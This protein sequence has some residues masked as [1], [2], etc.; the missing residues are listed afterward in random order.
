M[1]LTLDG[2]CA[3][4][5]EHPE[6]EKL[7][8]AFDKCEAHFLEYKPGHFIACHWFDFN[9]LDVHEQNEFWAVGTKH[10]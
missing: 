10:V 3:E 4:I 5:A 1:R 8:L 6:R 2:V 7:M 9:G